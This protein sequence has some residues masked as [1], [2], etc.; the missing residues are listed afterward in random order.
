MEAL[1]IK[2]YQEYNLRKREE[3]IYLT[4]TATIFASVVLLLFSNPPKQYSQSFEPTHIK[5]IGE[6]RQY[7]QQAI[8]DLGY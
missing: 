8:P 3:R 5:A 7:S 6:S 1:E 2:T 4:V